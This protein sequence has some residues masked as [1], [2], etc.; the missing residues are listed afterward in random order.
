MLIMMKRMGILLLALAGSV[1]G[2]AQTEV[3]VGVMRGKDYGVT[4][5]LPKSELRIALTVTRH[6]YTPGEFGKYAERYLHLSNVSV[7]PET[8]YTLDR[9]EA[10]SVGVPNKEHVYFVKMKDKTVAPLMQLT[11]DGIIKSINLPYKAPAAKEAPAREDV[12]APKT[13]PRSFLTQE[14]LMANST[15]KQAELVAKEIYTIRESKNALL[16]GEADN[17]PKDGAQLK[18]M[19][20]NLNEQEA[21]MTSM[22]VG[23]EVKQTTTTTLRIMP[24]ELEGEVAFRFSRKMGLVDKDNLV[25]EPYY[26]SIT[27]LTTP[28]IY[29]SEEGKKQLEGIAYNVPGLARVVLKQQNRKVF[30]TDM[31][32]TQFGVTEYLLPVLFNRN[33]TYWVLFDE[34]TGAILKSDRE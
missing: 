33:S 2:M 31:R 27:D 14:I 29:A 4:Y 34:N 7:R 21:A 23:G 17:M 18:L 10:A 19:L 25:G 8:Y 26:L 6:T 5:M 24:E 13:D 22:F 9:I 11:S 20:D 32:F 30:S 15:A 1:A 12:A 28:D 16:R 3:S